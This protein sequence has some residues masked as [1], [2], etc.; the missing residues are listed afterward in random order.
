MKQLVDWMT[1]KPA[2]VFGLPYGTLQENA[3]ADLTLV[4]LDK[5]LEIDKETFY[6]KGKNTPFHG[7]EVYG[8]PIMTVVDGEIVFKEETND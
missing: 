1:I 5:Q 2:E 7:W 3:P 6:S 4:D 8:F